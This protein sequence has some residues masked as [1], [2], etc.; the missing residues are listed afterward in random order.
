MNDEFIRGLLLA[1]L[2]SG[3][4]ALVVITLYIIINGGS[5]R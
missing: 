4:V 1:I 5:V 2:F 3:V